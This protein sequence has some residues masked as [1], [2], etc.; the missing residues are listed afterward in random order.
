VV[1]LVADESDVTLQDDAPTPPAAAVVA[2]ICQLVQPL[3]AL[4][5]TLSGA[6]SAAAGAVALLLCTSCDSRRL[7]SLMLS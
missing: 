2:P 5:L 6:L 1:Q 7:A 4:L 3:A